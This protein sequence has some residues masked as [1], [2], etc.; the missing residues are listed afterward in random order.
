MQMNNDNAASVDTIGNAMAM[1][2]AKSIDIISSAFSALLFAAFVEFFVGCVACWL[3][4]LAAN[5]M[6]PGAGFA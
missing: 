2:M 3:L 1:A 5:V 6:G 4:L